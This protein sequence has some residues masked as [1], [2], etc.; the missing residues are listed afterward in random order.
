M[1][2]LMANTTGI[3]VFAGVFIVAWVLCGVFSGWDHPVQTRFA[4]RG[5]SQISPEFLA[6]SLGL[7]L[8]TSASIAEIVRAGVLAVKAGQWDAGLALGM[9]MTETVS[10]VIFPQSMRLVIPPLASQYMNLTKNSSLAVMVGYPDLVNIG[11]TVI[12]VSAQALE[13][14]CIIMAV[15]LTLNLVISVVMNALNARIMRA[16][17]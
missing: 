1:T 9:T 13:V 8:F 16:P 17:Q 12:N 6:L 14:N 11:N 4:L 2:G 7:T 3:A 15:Y 10:Y 5:G